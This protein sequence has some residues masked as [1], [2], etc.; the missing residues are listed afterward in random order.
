MKILL[1]YKH[2]ERE[3]NAKLWKDSYVLS[4]ST[5]HISGLDG[6]ILTN[7]TE[8]NKYFKETYHNV[9]KVMGLLPLKSFLPLNQAVFLYYC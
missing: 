1:H 4:A 5:N 7:N 2:S 6:Q 9:F 8:E 3:T